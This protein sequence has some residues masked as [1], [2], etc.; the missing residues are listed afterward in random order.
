MKIELG[1]GKLTYVWAIHN[2]GPKKECLIKKL[3]QKITLNI[4]NV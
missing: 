3:V 1:F 4:H 2:Q